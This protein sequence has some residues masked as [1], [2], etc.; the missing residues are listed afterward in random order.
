MCTTIGLSEYDILL[1]CIGIR[2]A[3][4]KKKNITDYISYAKFYTCRPRNDHI[5][6][7]TLT[8]TADTVLSKWWY[9]LAVVQGAWLCYY[10]LTPDTVKHLLCLDNAPSLQMFYNCIS[11]WNVLIL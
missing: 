3:L 11:S 5:A 7:M 9:L 1:R 6:G 2:E 8:P 10:T 4:T